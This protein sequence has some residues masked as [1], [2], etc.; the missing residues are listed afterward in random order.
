MVVANQ[1]TVHGT[2]VASGISKWSPDLF[3]L[4]GREIGDY[5][6]EPEG[7]LTLIHPDDRCFVQ[8]Q[9]TLGISSIGHEIEYFCRMRHA[10]GQWLTFLCKGWVDRDELSRPIRVSGSLTQV[11]SLTNPK[12]TAESDRPSTGINK[13]PLTEL[14]LA[15]DARLSKAEYRL[16]M[17]LA[18]SRLGVFDWDLITNT[19]EWDRQHESLWGLESGQ[20]PGAL[21]AFID[22]LHPD[23]ASQVMHLLE[24][25]RTNRTPFFCCFR[26]IWPDK[27]EHWIESR[28]EFTY[29][30]D[31]VAIRMFGTVADVTAHQNSQIQLKESEARFRSL[32]EHLPIAYQSLDAQGRWLDANEAFAKLLGYSSPEDMIGKDFAAHFDEE[33]R[34][35]FWEYFERFKRGEDNHQEFVLRKKDGTQIIVDTAGR[36]Q[37]DDQGQF[38]RSHRILIDLTERSEYLHATEQLNKDL[39][40]KVNERTE[41]NS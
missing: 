22:G 30:R 16:R 18:N 3:T 35:Q 40:L 15:Q 38:L 26:V 2:S 36:I 9:M 17:A 1:C 7:A 41:Q 31:G 21:D 11:R 23:D 13:N 8:E 25:A 14:S 4:L 34:P 39:E 37:R 6:P 12:N 24:A 10:E 33:T 27:S 20:F 32:F 29:G 19:I 28:G 5:P